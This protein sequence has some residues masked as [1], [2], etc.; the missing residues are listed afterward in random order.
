MKSN[1]DVLLKVTTEQNNQIAELHQRCATMQSFHGDFHSIIDKLHEVT[2][3]QQG[4]TE[5]LEQLTTRHQHRL[6]AMYT[7]LNNQPP[8]NEDLIANVQLLHQAT[9]E[10]QDRY[11]AARDAE[12]ATH[13]DYMIMPQ[14]AEDSGSPPTTQ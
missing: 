3:Q 12:Q 14:Y 13:D 6:D 11:N 1:L 9:R 5:D 4:Q 7:T 8:I 10:L 2:H